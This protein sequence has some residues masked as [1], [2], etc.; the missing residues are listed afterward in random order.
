[1]YWD[2]IASKII[3]NGLA[4]RRRF[5][6]L[7]FGAQIFAAQIEGHTFGLMYIRKVAFIRVSTSGHWSDT[8]Q[9]IPQCVS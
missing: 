6:L 7:R 9:L 8:I 1:M 5:I 2:F 4:L 3:A